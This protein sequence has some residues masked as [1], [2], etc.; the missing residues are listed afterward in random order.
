MITR[1]PQQ[2]PERSDSV[3]DNMEIP[4]LSRELRAIN[5][6]LDAAARVDSF[7]GGPAR[8]SPTNLAGFPL[9]WRFGGVVVGDDVAEALLSLHDFI[10]DARNEGCYS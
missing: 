9:R 5:N 6:V 4:V 8:R 10:N 3:I 1:E 7:L 2:L